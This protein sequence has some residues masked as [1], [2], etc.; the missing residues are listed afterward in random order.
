MKNVVIIFRKNKKSII[1]SNYFCYEVP[2]NP[3]RR[4]LRYPRKAESNLS[5]TPLQLIDKET[6][7]RIAYHNCVRSLP[8]LV[9]KLKERFYTL[10]HLP[11]A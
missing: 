9:A 4:S 11:F 6:F 8:R 7:S 5:G 10:Y 2:I 1:P 3:K